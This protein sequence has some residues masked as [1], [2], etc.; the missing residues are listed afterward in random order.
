[1]GDNGTILKFIDKY[2]S[3]KK[4]QLIRFDEFIAVEFE[5]KS[6]PPKTVHEEIVA[7]LDLIYNEDE[8]AERDI[9]Y[10]ECGYIVYTHK[11]IDINKEPQPNNVSWVE[12]K[13]SV[14]HP[15]AEE[16]LNRL[17]SSCITYIN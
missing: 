12:I 17:F 14:D 13:L 7:I 8:H 6:S 2:M 3:E 4:G 16:I 9:Y 5:I 15:L 1:M 11:G 10:D